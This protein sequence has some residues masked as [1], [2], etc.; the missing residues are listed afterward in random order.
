M[1]LSFSVEQIAKLGKI[2]R[3]VDSLLNELPEFSLEWNE[4]NYIYVELENIIKAAK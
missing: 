4:L 2:Q 3:E 1:N